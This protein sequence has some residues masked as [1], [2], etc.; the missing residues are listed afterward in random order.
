MNHIDCRS[1]SLWTIVLAVFLGGPIGCPGTGNV[2]A[3]VVGGDGTNGNE[4][5]DNGSGTDPS[6]TMFFVSPTGDDTSGGPSPDSPLRTIG[7]AAALAGPGDT[8]A[9]LPGTY[10][11]A[12]KMEDVGDASAPITIRAEGGVAVLDGGRDLDVGFWCDNCVN[13]VIDGI[14]FRN[15]TDAGV[16]IVSSRNITLRNLTVHGNGFEAKM[17]EI[18]GYGIVADDSSDILIENNEVFE[19]GPQPQVLGRWLG[20]GIDAFAITDSIIRN[21]NSH[22]NIGGGLLVEDSINVLVEGNTITGNELDA[23][24]EDWW[25]GAIWVDGGRD[26]TLRNN[27]ITGNNG[28]GV[29]ISD[30]DN[31]QPSGYVLEGNTIRENKFGLYIWNFGTNELPPDNILTLIDNDISDNTDLK[32]WIVDWECPP[33]APCEP[34]D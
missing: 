6:V 32:F 17:E 13:F 24:V 3:A 33:E 7:R 16:L 15:Y 19:N 9:I 11:E 10:Q 1:L 14:E 25:D 21:N 30:E 26:I 34:S 4:T 2:G 29:E 20:T 23:T 12:I 22:D 31:R 18:E 8:I 5:G 27:T 28:P